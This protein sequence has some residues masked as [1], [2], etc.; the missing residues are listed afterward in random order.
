M[1]LS[2]TDKAVLAEAIREIEAK[3]RAEIVMVVRG[4]SD[5][6]DG[7][8][9]LLA[10]AAA[11]GVLA[12]TLFSDWEFSL[13]AIGTLPLLAALVVVAAA[14]FIPSVERGLSSRARRRQAVEQAAR[15]T[16]VERGV[17]HTRERTG[18]L[19]CVSRLE[20]EAVVVPDKGITDVIAPD[21]WAG[22]V[23]E[24]H[25]VAA[26]APGD[27]RAMAEALRAMGARLA[28]AVPARAD[29]VDELPNAVEVRS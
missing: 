2:G 7:G 11:F 26:T 14:R 15:A 13:L 25:R 22:A 21:A 17:G 6:Y 19:V 16:F 1:A 9:V 29:D 8:P 12:F 18:V 4:R 24:I 27:G 28:R 23:A 3:S 5:T 20:R 10:A